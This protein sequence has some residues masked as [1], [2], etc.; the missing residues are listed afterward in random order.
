MS[1]KKRSPNFFSKRVIS[2]LKREKRIRQNLLEGPFLGKIISYTIP[3]V[4]TSVLQLL[5][6]TADLMVL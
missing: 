5:F 2:L 1:V 3:V 6:N 4:L